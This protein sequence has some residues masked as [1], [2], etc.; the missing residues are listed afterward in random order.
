MD[1]IFEKG[2]FTEGELEQAII[3]LFEQQGYTYVP[4][5]SIHRRCEDILLTDDIRSYLVSRYNNDLSDVEI[6]KVINKLRLINSTPLYSGNRE[7]FRLV[8]EGFDLG[9][10]DITQVAM[11]V[12][13]IDFDHPENNIFKVINQYGFPPARCASR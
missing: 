8:T 11:H 4:G 5:E 1:Y 10:D 12:D 6:Q 13:Y 7:S 2:K 9:R 3:E